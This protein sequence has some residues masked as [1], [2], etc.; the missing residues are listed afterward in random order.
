MNLIFALLF[1]LTLPPPATADQPMAA[2]PDAREILG[3]PSGSGLSG[4]V[5]ERETQ[6]VASLLRCPVCQGLSVADSPAAMALNMKRQVRDLLS[7]GYSRDQVLRYFEASYG[8]FVRLEP[9]R[10]GINWLVWLGPVLALLVGA[11]VVLFTVRQGR[12]APKAESVD[13][14][15]DPYLEQVRQMAYG[16][17]PEQES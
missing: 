14:D 13:R 17:G 2:T 5:L 3:P 4:E 7:W 1:L 11:V 8:Q 12:A 10:H 16:K 15:L 6:H 9:P